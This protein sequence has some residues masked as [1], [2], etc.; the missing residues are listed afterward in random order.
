MSSPDSITMLAPGT[1][2]QSCVDILGVLKAHK[3]A[4]PFLK[5]VDA[6][7][8]PDY[9]QIVRDPTDLSTIEA[10][11]L[12]SIYANPRCFE[13]EV[14]TMFANAY[15]Y[16]RRGSDVYRMCQALE[17][18]FNRWSPPEAS[19]RSG[20]KRRRPNKYT[21][22]E[23]DASTTRT[24]PRRTKRRVSNGSS[25]RALAFQAEVAALK[26]EIDEIK[27]KMHSCAHALRQTKQHLAHTHK[28]TRQ[29]KEEL[30]EEVCALT[31]KQ[32]AHVFKIVCRDMPAFVEDKCGE[33]V[34]NVDLNMM[35]EATFKRVRAYVKGV[36]Y[37]LAKK[38]C[39]SA[40]CD[41]VSAPSCDDV[42]VI[43][44]GGSDKERWDEWQRQNHETQQQNQ[45]E[46]EE[47]ESESESESDFESDQDEGSDGE[48]LTF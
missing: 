25:P 45:D 48:V 38:K 16:N 43:T 10:K 42:C 46:Q 34:V 17:R 26:Q 1:H 35:D 6:S 20:R 32:Q 41:P 28:S 27:Q 30:V 24:K 29:T 9:Y 4:G 22:T 40:N 37:R 5:P 18:R 33:K 31:S 39:E 12:N 3:H 36:K 7:I 23:E 11:L 47:F 2:M 21:T 8:V 14:R 15:V 44:V 13:A 19:R